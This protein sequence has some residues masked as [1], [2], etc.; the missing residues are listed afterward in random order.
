MKAGA[1]KTSR[2][3]KTTVKKSGIAGRTAKKAANA[4]AS[5]RSAKQGISSSRAAKTGAPTR[6][7]SRRYLSPLGKR[8]I[9]SRRLTAAIKA[10]KKTHAPYGLEM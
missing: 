3:R 4:K 7:I 6:V 8:E 5:A 9:S 2:S 10:V 1:R